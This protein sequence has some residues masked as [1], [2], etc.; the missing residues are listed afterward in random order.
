[1]GLKPG[2]LARSELATPPP[3]GSTGPRPSGRLSLMCRTS[4]RHQQRGL[5]RARSAQACQGQPEERE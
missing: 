5:P 4:W 3:S 1:M 2:L